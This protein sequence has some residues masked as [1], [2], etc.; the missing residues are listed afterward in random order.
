MPAAPIAFQVTAPYF[1]YGPKELAHLS[2]RDARLARAIEA[3]GPVRR[4]VRPDFFAALMHAIV[5]QQIATKAQETVWTRLETALGRVTPATVAAA[6]TELLQKQ[7]LSYR[8]VSYMQA[9]AAA[10]LCGDLDPEALRRLDD[11]ALCAALCRLNGV[12]VWTAEML[13]LFSLQRPDILSWG[14]LA[15]QR[16]L[17]MLYRHKEMPRERFERCRRRY[18][19]YGS[20]ASLYLWAIAGGALPELT[21]PAARPPQ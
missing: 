1:C 20:V 3:I 10:A 19:P 5:G 13:M 11:A 21:D 16:G 6:G 12:G 14:D 2:R 18:S 7:G 17:R 8:K 15:I 9:A 4:T